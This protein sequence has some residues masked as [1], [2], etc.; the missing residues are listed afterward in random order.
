MASV[1]LA[2]TTEFVR[3]VGGLWPLALIIAAV[4]LVF[5]F[6]RELVRAT[7]DGRTRFRFKRGGTEV[8]VE[9]EV[10]TPAGASTDTDEGRDAPLQEDAL[11]V[12]GELE[13]AESEEQLLSERERMFAALVARDA[14]EA[15]RRFANVQE[16]EEDSVQRL[17]NQADFAYWRVLFLKDG[18][19]IQELDALRAEEDVAE[20]ARFRL[21]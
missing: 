17:F 8:E 19:A 7:S 18:S 11:L 12:E 13:L 1:T 15:S 10:A 21:V 9:R 6:R 4:I 16:Q 5:V 3:A 14:S 2:S 20:F